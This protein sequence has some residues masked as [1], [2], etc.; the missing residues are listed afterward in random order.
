MPNENGGVP[1]SDAEIDAL[2]DAV[3]AQP[4]GT[5]RRA[6]EELE[7][8]LPEAVAALRA[9][10]KPRRVRSPRPRPRRWIGSLE[11]WNRPSAPLGR[12]DR[13]EARA[14]TRFRSGEDRCNRCSLIWERRHRA[15]HRCSSTT[16]RETCAEPRGRARVPWA[17]G[18]NPDV[19][20]RGAPPPDTTGAWDFRSRGDQMG[21]LFIEAATRSPWDHETLYRLVSGSWFIHRITG[22][23]VGSAPH[24]RRVEWRPVTP[25]AALRWLRCFGGSAPG[26]PDAL[27]RLRQLWTTEGPLAAIQRRATAPS[28]A[29]VS[30]GR[31][32]AR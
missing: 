5:H 7:R 24:R 19:C 6:V 12:C 25:K 14:R 18:R 11:K 10:P 1:R 31:T 23:H 30:S 9:L 13:C 29:S 27:D 28:R 32:Q 3:F 17:T 22:T 21:D 26:S 4:L 16:T 15:A 20:A 2:L 8:T